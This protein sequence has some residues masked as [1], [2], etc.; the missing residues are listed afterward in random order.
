MKVSFKFLCLLFTLLP[1]QGITQDCGCTISDVIDNS[2]TPLDTVIGATTVVN[3]VAE[4]QAAINLANGSGGNMTILI[5]DGTYQVASTASYPYLTASNVVIRSQSGKRDQVVLTGTGMS[6]VDPLTENVL[7]I[8]GDNVIISDLTIKDA[9]N[10]GISVQGDNL[11]VHNVK[12]QDTYQQLFKGT[13]ANGGAD[14][15]NVQCSLMEYTAGVGPNFY[16][17]GLDIHDGD[18]W[19]VN[20]NVFRNISSPSGSVAEHAVH[21]WNSSADNVIERNMILNCDRGIGFGLGSSA[22]DGGIIRNNMIFND[23][24]SLF[25]DVGI[26]LETSPNTKVY[27]NTIF[28]EY[29]NA[30]E[31][32]YPA[33][34]NVD[35][36][37]NLTNQN[38]QSRNGGIANVY[39]NKTDALSSWFVNPTLGNLRLNANIN[40]VVDAGTAIQDVTRDIDKYARPAAFDIGAH[41]YVQPELLPLIQID[42]LKYE[43]AFIIPSGNFGSGSNY[44]ADYSSGGI[45]INSENNSLFLAGHDPTHIVAEFSI[46]PLVNSTTLS[47]LNTSTVI[48]NFKEVL[49][50]TANPQGIDRIT[51][52]AVIDSKL[53]INAMEFYGSIF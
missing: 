51:G 26:G 50:V 49:N 44:T 48:Q 12:I 19:T 3:S 2:V 8:V 16:I 35:I 22:N 42:H 41:E 39:S 52:M 32:R 23:G 1:L 4:F 46:P 10:H 45:A 9:G 36:A 27:N 15:C 34:T 5:T 21:F 40:L 13:S 37:N 31:Y 18:Q 30:I 6:S 24:T 14:N 33:T 28:I 20:D 17:G 7:S 25:H 29:Q 43:G 11:F 38:I 47:D 53:V